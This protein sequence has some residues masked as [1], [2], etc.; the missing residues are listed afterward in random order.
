MNKA[1]LKYYTAG[2]EFILCSSHEEAVVRELSHQTGS[3]QIILLRGFSRVIHLQ[4]RKQSLNISNT[5][6]DE[7]RL[8]KI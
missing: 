7:L 1:D 5:G 6:F 8:A 3:P 4:K 2:V